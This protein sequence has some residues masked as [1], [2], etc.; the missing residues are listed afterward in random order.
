MPHA[1]VIDS[2]RDHIWVALKELR[3]RIT[4]ADAV[5]EFDNGVHGVMDEDSIWLYD[6]LK[7]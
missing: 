4:P 1:L 2:S 5:F 7:S 6:Q 3:G